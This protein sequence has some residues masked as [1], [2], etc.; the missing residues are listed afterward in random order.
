M[1]GNGLWGGHD[2]VEGR[3]SCVRPLTEQKRS[4]PNQHHYLQARYVKHVLPMVGI[5]K[6]CV[7]MVVNVM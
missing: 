6:L 1:W 3:L 2:G 4:R 7:Q 5:G